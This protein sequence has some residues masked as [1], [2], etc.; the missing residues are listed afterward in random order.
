MPRDRLTGLETC[1]SRIL[2]FGWIKSGYSQPMCNRQCFDGWE[3]WPIKTRLQWL[4]VLKQICQTQVRNVVIRS[5]TFAIL[6]TE[7]IGYV[8]V[9]YTELVST[10]RFSP[11]LYLTISIMDHRLQ[12]R[13]CG[14]E[15]IL[16]EVMRSSDEEQRRREMHLR[17]RCRASVERRC[18]FMDS[19]PF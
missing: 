5:C 8:L 2:V 12:K 14:V 3:Y 7:R 16:E 15:S 18:L 9:R 4:T 11:K 1:Q 19:I 17:T 6:R 10:H 13:F